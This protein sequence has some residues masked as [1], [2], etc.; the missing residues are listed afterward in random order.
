MDL[1][2]HF[3]S[4]DLLALANG[5]QLRAVAGVGPNI[6]EAILD[7][8]GRERNQKILEKLKA[9]GV[10]PNFSSDLTRTPGGPLTGMTFVVTGALTGFSRDGVKEFIE[11]NGGKVTELGQQ[12]NQLPR[13]RRSSGIEARESPV[14]GSESHQR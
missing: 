13:G 11:Q 8:F 10:W 14:I 4:L 9:A 1:S 6:A 3:P 2:R 12:K 5:E 7:W